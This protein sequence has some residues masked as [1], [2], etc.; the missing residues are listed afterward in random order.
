MRNYIAVGMAY[1]AFVEWD[2]DA[3]DDQLA[4]FGEAMQVVADAAADAHAFCS[5]CK[6]KRAS[7][8][9]AGLVILMLRSEP[10]ITWTSYPRRSTRPASSEALAPSAS[11]RAK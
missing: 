4:P 1:R 8:M 3:A 6:I 5:S 10:W 9:S 7:S 2:F 11:A